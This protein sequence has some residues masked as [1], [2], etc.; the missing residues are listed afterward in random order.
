MKRTRNRPDFR[1]GLA[2][3]VTV[4]VAAV[5]TAMLFAAIS[6]HV[7]LTIVLAVAIAGLTIAFS[8]LLK[9]QPRLETTWSSLPSGG[10][11]KRIRRAQNS[12][13]LVTSS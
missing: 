11:P 7:T 12:Q 3:A 1:K 5:E 8:Y 13:L 2:I 10:R 9:R 6:T 4:G